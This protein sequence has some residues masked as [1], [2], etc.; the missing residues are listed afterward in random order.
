MNVFERELKTMFTSNDIIE[1]P[2]ISGKTLIG[3]IDTDLIVKL[4]FIT[5]EVS[6]NYD[7]INV[8][9]INRT[10]GPVDEQRFMFSDIIG[11]QQT[12]S[13]NVVNP[14]IWKTVNNTDWYIPITITQKA[15]IGDAVLDY[16]GMF[17][18][19]DMNLAQSFL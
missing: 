13:G 19:Q 9:I 18:S 3:R 14:H 17:Q 12:K 15:E 11:T 10:T 16:V 1:E 8:K 7:A 6:N 4:Q 2:K 5:T